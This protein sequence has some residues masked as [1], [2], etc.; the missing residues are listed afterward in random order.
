MERLNITA[1]CTFGLEGILKEELLNL[2]YDD[3]TAQNGKVEISGTMEDVARCNIWLRT[4]D[5]VLIKIAEFQATTFDELFEKTKEC[6]WERW[7]SKSSQF[8]VAKA[9]SVK[10]V[11][12]SKSDCQSIV[13]KAVVEKLKKFYKIDWFEETGTLVPIHVNI[14][15]NM[16]TL[17]IDTTGMGLHKRGYRLKS[18]EAPI[19]ETLAAAMV[20]LS[21][22]DV[23]RQFADPFCG[24]GTIAI[25]A[26][27]IGKNMAPG[28]NREF[29]SETWDNNRYMYKRIKELAHEQEK[30]DE[31]I[32]F[33]SDIDNKTISIAVDNAIRAGVKDEVQ[34]K[35]RDIKDFES[36]SKYGVI[37]TNPPY[38]ERL[39]T[40]KEVERLYAVMGRTFAKLEQWSY[41]ILS[42]HLNFEKYFGK[43]SN[44]NRKLY[45]G[46]LITYLYQ[47]YGT[48]PERRR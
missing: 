25:E 48:L 21:K 3:V 36:Q 29:I 38:G 14:L 20:Y 30:E 34:Y 35:A 16:V 9:T 46:N 2:G 18:N 1:T 7:I 33:A 41:F 32:V 5:R 8:P 28:V 19:K 24:S 15:K 43:K 39:S 6:Q 17:S 44:K 4:A 22:W 47:Y 12:F 26:A 10:S 11:L 45:N 31:F 23:T 42:G 13:K 40:K 27:M 37:I